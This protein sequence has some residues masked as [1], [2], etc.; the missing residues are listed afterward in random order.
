MPYTIT[1][2][3]PNA[4]IQ[5]AYA[6]GREQGRLRRQQEQS[7]FGQRVALQG[8]QIA[9]QDER[10][11]KTIAAQADRA[12]Q[13]REWRAYDA[14]L[15]FQ[16][17]QSLQ[18]TAAALKQLD[19]EQ[20]KDQYRKLGALLQNDAFLDSQGVMDPQHRAVLRKYGATALQFPIEVGPQAMKE[21][22]LRVTGAKTPQEQQEHMRKIAEQERVSVEGRKAA[23]DE[24]KF[25]R[26]RA[27]KLRDEE[28]KHEAEAQY[29]QT[30]IDQFEGQLSKTPDDVAHAESRQK[31]NEYISGARAAKKKAETL[32]DMAYEERT[33][34]KPVA[35]TAPISAGPK[36][37]SPE[38]IAAAG[39]RGAAIRAGAPTAEGTP[40]DPIT[41][42]WNYRNT[43]RPNGA[44]DG[45]AAQGLDDVVKLPTVQT[46]DDY[47][48][49][50][51]GTMFKA[52]DGTTRRKP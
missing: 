14:D 24:E 27:M 6:A 42:P 50:P 13:N 34:Q 51:S 19:R 30:M 48:A 11:G 35:T 17:Q 8:Q 1:H 31:L 45:G 22:A 16:R 18:E 26:D 9:A 29:Q 3:D 47:A 40:P 4:L 7:A 20:Q 52:P 23:A 10:Q 49:L 44:A 5:S 2:G 41:V 39:D 33:G 25:V 32:R 43:T 28:R 37:G 21:L 12:K 46:D 36:P 38:S 15:H